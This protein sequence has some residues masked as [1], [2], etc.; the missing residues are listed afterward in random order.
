V[1]G[2]QEYSLDDL[3]VI[4]GFLEPFNC[5]LTTP[6][7]MT[8]VSNLSGRFRHDIKQLFRRMLRDRFLEVLD[9]K[10]ITTHSAALHPFFDQLGVT[11]AAIGVLADQGLLVLTNDLDLTLMLES[12]NLDC[13]HY[14][15][16]LRPLALNL[17]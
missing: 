2:T 1:K 9:E 13:V 16:T 10:Y 12:R 15:R 11:D 14:D 3:R 8:E 6:N 7:I 4:G 17:E 5:I